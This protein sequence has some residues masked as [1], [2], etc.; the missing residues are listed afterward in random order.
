LYDVSTDLSDTSETIVDEC[1]LY[2]KLK[3][4]CKSKL[5]IKGSLLNK[6][7]VFNTKSAI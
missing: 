7:N 2:I 4:D 1:L 5:R 3:E 6:L